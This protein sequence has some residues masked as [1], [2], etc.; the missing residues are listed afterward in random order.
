M[1]YNLHLELTTRC[2]LACPACPRTIFFQ[3]FNCPYPKHDLDLDDLASF[4]D[5]KSGK[6][7]GRIECNGNHGDLIYYPR[8]LEF[9]ERFRA[10]RYNLHTSGANQTDKFWNEISARLEA[11]DTVIFSI[12]GLE[13]T[14][15]L[16]R[17]NARWQSVQRA[18]EIVSRSPAKIIWKTIVFGFNQMQ[19]DAI[20]CRAETLGANFVAVQTHR[21]G[22]D[23]LRPSDN[24]IHWARD[25]SR[26][27]LA[28]DID[29]LC[30][31][32]QYVSADGYYTPCCWS[33]VVNIWPKTHFYRDRQDWTIKGHTLD[34][35]QSRIESWAN[36][37]REKLEPA[38]DICKMHCKKNQQVPWNPELVTTVAQ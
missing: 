12:D 36:G 13:N 11:I 1:K 35:F 2:T 20:R 25:W 19:I 6:E 14:N 24:L 8:L 22:D 31:S 9:L 21:F 23:N 37:I 30:P 5:C 10:W 18:V 15:H 7:L 33:H 32:M 17:K 38:Y 29:P 27:A 3:K 34:D 16:Y 28:E 4:L 26:S